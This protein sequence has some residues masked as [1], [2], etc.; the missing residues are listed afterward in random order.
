MSG[1]LKLITY[2]KASFVD[3]R[4]V[5]LLFDIK[6]EKQASQETQSRKGRRRRKEKNRSAKDVEIFSYSSSLFLFSLSIFLT[7]GFSK[8]MLLSPELA[9]LM[10]ET[11]VRYYLCDCFGQCASSFFTTMIYR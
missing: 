5:M 3:S 2:I 8:P 11:H 9:D 1:I 4:F 7:V 10:G 6:G